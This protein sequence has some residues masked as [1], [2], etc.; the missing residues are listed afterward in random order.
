MGY[1]KL[2]RWITKITNAGKQLLKVRR[3]TGL[4]DVEEMGFC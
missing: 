2:H 4:S 3:Q 1:Q